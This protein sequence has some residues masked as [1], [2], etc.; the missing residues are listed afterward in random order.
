M[1]DVLEKKI[2]ENLIIN[3]KILQLKIE[4]GKKKIQI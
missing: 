2:D 4:I 1:E 3:P